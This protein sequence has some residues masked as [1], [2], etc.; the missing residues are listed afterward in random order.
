MDSEAQQAALAAI[1]RLGHPRELR[2]EA[3]ALGAGGVPG[4]DERGGGA[5]ERENHS[6]MIVAFVI[7][8]TLVGVDLSGPVVGVALMMSTTFMLSSSFTLPKTQ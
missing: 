8:T 6:L 1:E 7:F 4:A 3:R 2:L 5:N